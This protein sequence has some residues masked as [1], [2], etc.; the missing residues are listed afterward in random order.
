MK[1]FRASAQKY[2]TDAMSDFRTLGA[3]ALQPMSYRTTIFLMIAVGAVALFMCLN[4]V[5]AATT[6]L[7]QTLDSAVTNLYNDANGMVETVA[8]FALVISIIGVFVASMFGPKAT[9]V[10][11]SALK[12]VIFFFIFWQLIPV[13]LSTI[14]NLFGSGA[15][16]GNTP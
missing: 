10:M 5:F 6:P 2:K 9:S 15:S 14:K 12:M 16:G 8:T 3:A 7:F 13:I 11:T 1:N 4:S